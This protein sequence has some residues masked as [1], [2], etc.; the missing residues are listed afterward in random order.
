MGLLRILSG[1]MGYPGKIVAFWECLHF[2]ACN[3]HYI[4]LYTDYDKKSNIPF[5]QTRLQFQLPPM[6]AKHVIFYITFCICTGIASGALAQDAT[7]LI[8][9]L[10]VAVACDVVFAS[11]IL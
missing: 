6:I 8:G 1:F 10:A 3:C 11:V 9:Y 5:H 7:H 2:G 4:R